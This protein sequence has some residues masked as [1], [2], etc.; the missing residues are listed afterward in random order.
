MCLFHDRSSIYGIDTTFSGRK[1][2]MTNAKSSLITIHNPTIAVT[3][4]LFYNRSAYILQY[5]LVFKSNNQLYRI[6]QGLGTHLFKETEF[7]KKM[8]YN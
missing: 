2:I 6:T 1:L 5:F 8:H 4:G 3:M 7:L